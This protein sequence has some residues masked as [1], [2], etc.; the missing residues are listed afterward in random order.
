MKFKDINILVFLFLS[1]YLI[2]CSS[3]EYDLEKVQVEYVEKS[4]KY[5]TLETLITD[6]VLNKEDLVINTST[7]E[8]FTF[9]VQIGA[10]A[11]PDNFERFYATAKSVVGDE[12]Y[13]KVINNLY[14]IRL[15]NYS[16]KADALI[17]LERMKNLGYFDAF[18]VTVINK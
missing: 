6:T 17:T 15:G 18:I 10:F 9:I 5:D 11:M 12:I 1:A 2:G 3:G 14:K 13:Y 16:N 4:L 8:T 7:K